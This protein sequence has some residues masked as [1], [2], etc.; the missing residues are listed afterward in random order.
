VAQQPWYTRPGLRTLGAPWRK[1][2][3]LEY[4]LRS[5][6][7]ELA[8]HANRFGSD[9][10]SKRAVRSYQAALQSYATNPWVF[11]A[12]QVRAQSV[13]NV[14][15]LAYRDI[16][17]APAEEPE[18][19]AKTQKLKAEVT[20]EEICGNPKVEKFLTRPNRWQSFHELMEETQTNLDLSGT[21]FWELGFNEDPEK[22]TPDMKPV[23]AFTGQ[24]WGIRPDAM[25]PVG[26]KSKVVDHF[27]FK[28]PGA[29]K[30]QEFHPSRIVWF[31]NYSPYGPRSGM[32]WVEV[33]QDLL[34]MDSA[35]R[36]WNVNQV[37]GAGPDVILSTEKALNQQARQQNRD[38]WIKRVMSR[39]PMQRIAV[40]DMGMKAEVLSLAH[41]DMQF[42]EQLQQ[43]IQELLAASG[44]PPLLMTILEHANYANSD[45]QQKFFWETG[46]KPEVDKRWSTINLSVAPLFGE[47]GLYFEPDWSGVPYL[48]EDENSRITRL[49]AEVG[50]GITT[51]NE[52]RAEIGREGDVPWGDEHPDVGPFLGLVPDAPTGEPSEAPGDDGQGEATPPGAGQAVDVV[53]PANAVDP[54]TGLNSA[55]IASMRAIVGDV[56][57]G[58]IPRSSGV[59][60]LAAS[61]PFSE[62]QAD[63]ILGDIGRGFEPP[64]P[65]EVALAAVPGPTDLKRYELALPGYVS[66]SGQRL[67]LAK[68]VRRGVDRLQTRGIVRFADPVQDYLDAKARE[69]VRGVERQ[70]R[71]ADLD[72]DWLDN[73]LGAAANEE[74]FALLTEAGLTTVYE[75]G[76]FGAQVAG[77]AGIEGISFDLTAAIR[78]AYLE[79]LEVR[80]K[81][82]NETMA[83]QARRS[84]LMGIEQGES[85]GDLA[86]RVESFYEQNNPHRAIMIARTESG[87]AVN[88][89]TLEGYAVA[90]VSGKEWLSSRDGRVRPS[91]RAMDGTVVGLRESFNVSGHEMQFPRDLN[92]GPP[93]ETINC[94]CDLIPDL[95]GGR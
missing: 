13:A 16:P 60:M 62:E 72:L 95:E 54:G 5:A 70:K 25:Q 34:A 17:A 15:A 19:Q 7:A 64:Q 80:S 33:V 71:K 4:R 92:N 6:Q 52:A 67:M 84:L 68:T 12:V 35:L 39:D 2:E 45:A 83:S 94:R 87:A 14:P 10:E 79:N 11:R 24:A 50:A 40:M 66:R 22:I 1:L 42:R 81:L 82:M 93:D 89:G 86:R 49:V 76:V 31:N 37:Q 74:L 91:H 88:G 28:P 38:E 69:I 26:T 61:L 46:V 23:G 77:A 43:I 63:K 36:D 21:M 75:A 30:G 59:A 55:Q 8:A 9:G 3:S 41:R 20:R 53:D 57:T 78:S 56:A 85:I 51:A 32:G 90:G 48:R 29:Q 44:V 18:G 58:A 65:E 47:D 27:L 73:I